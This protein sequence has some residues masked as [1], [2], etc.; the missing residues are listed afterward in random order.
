MEKVE[1]M[2]AEEGGFYNPEEAVE[3]KKT[4]DQNQNPALAGREL[5]A[6]PKQNSAVGLAKAMEVDPSHSEYFALY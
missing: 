1:K 5:G 6:R 2:V 3:E 4:V